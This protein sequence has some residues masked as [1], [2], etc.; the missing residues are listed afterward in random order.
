[1]LEVRAWNLAE[2]C[3]K[4]K[5]TTSS[6][7]QALDSQSHSAVYRRAQR[8]AAYCGLGR[9]LPEHVG[10]RAGG[11]ERMS[12]LEREAK[13]ATGEPLI[14][15]ARLSKNFGRADVLRE[16]DFSVAEGEIVC[17]IG[18]SGSGKSTLLRCLNLLVE[19]SEG[20]LYFRGTETGSWPRS[21]G[22]VQAFHWRKQVCQHRRKIGMVFQHFELF[23]HLSAA[24]NVALGPRRVLGLSKGEANNRA[25][26]ILSRVGL[27]DFVHV[28]PGQLSGGQKQRVAIA[29]ALAMEPEL[30]LLDEPTS[31]LDP[32]MVSGIL[33][34]LVELA[35]GGLTMVAVT[36]E[37]GFATQVADRVVVIDDGR[38]AEEAT[39]RQLL[40][41][42]ASAAAQSFI[43][44]LTA[45]HDFSARNGRQNA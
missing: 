38:V 44:K 12:S 7:V 10:S 36:H 35:L 32:E 37:L 9:S 14:Q 6:P 39:P 19:P 45:Y 24:Q 25:K 17:I 8:K 42:P 26:T 18:R 29:R 15:A 22:P 4:G 11:S 40:E 16:V 28:R 33:D 20:S 41:A 1:M 43:Q 13:P 27:A 2:A 3:R 21:L 34:L 23:P 30:L 5:L 31:A